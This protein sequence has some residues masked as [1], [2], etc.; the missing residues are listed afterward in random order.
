MPRHRLRLSLQHHLDGTARGFAFGIGDQV[1]QMQHPRHRPFTADPGAY[2]QALSAA[3]PPYPGAP[4]GGLFPGS[5]PAF[6]EPS[7]R[8]AST[9]WRR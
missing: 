6:T 2:P 8:S 3:Q 7:R 4:P 1:I 5:E 9:S